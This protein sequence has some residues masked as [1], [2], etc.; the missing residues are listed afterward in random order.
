MQINKVAFKTVASVN[1]S[2]QCPGCTEMLAYSKKDYCFWIITDSIVGSEG[3]LLS[4][5]CQSKKVIS[6]FASSFNSIYILWNEPWS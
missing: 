3:I 5:D 2:E 1:N 4:R 6:P